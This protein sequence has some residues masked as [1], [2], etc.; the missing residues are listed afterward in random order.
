M[1]Y[2]KIKNGKPIKVEKWSNTVT[3]IDILTGIILAKKEFSDHIMAIYVA[4]S[5]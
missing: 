5:L 1:K 2:N 4:K 3:V